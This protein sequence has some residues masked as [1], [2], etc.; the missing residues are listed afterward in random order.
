[1]YSSISTPS[2][3]S[4]QHQTAFSTTK[5]LALPVA[6]TVAPKANPF[7]T[8]AQKAS[9]F[10]SHGNIPSSYESIDRNKN[11]FTYGAYNSNNKYRTT[12]ATNLIAANAKM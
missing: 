11:Q 8:L 1:M 7:M 10:S 4:N 9:I 6:A 5:S 3:S 2:T 12:S